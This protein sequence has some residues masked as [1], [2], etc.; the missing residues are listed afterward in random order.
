MEFH[1]LKQQIHHGLNMFQEEI[2]EYL[3]FLVERCVMTRDQVRLR[4]IY[5]LYNQTVLSRFQF[6]PLTLGRGYKHLSSD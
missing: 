3:M 5:C 2:I 1:L 6:G 4:L